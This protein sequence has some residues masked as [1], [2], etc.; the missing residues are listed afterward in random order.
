MSTKHVMNHHFS[1]GIVCCCVERGR[2]D[3]CVFIAVSPDIAPIQMLSF[4][5]MKELRKLEIR[6]NRSNNKKTA[7]SFVLNEAAPVGFSV[8]QSFQDVPGNFIRPVSLDCKGY[9]KMDCEQA[10]VAMA[11]SFKLIKLISRKQTHVLESCRVGPAL[12]E[13]LD[14]RKVTIRRGVHGSSLVF[15]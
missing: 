14:P 12:G 4:G 1:D 13:P 3:Q 7:C 6:V 15:V 9:W 11:D 8:S 5:A 2:G 10:C